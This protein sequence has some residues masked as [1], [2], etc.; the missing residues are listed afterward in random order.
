MLLYLYLETLYLAVLNCS[1]TPVSIFEPK[2]ETLGMAICSDSCLLSHF[3]DQSFLLL[4]KGT[5][6]HSNRQIKISKEKNYTWGKKITK[7]LCKFLHQI[8]LVLEE[9]TWG[10]CSQYILLIRILKSKPSY[11]FAYSFKERS[12]ISEL[13]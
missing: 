8:C 6:F 7:G 12:S 5:Y 13:C 1:N 3:C 11:V 4:T 9:S 2:S 10:E